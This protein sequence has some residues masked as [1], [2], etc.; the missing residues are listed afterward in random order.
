MSPAMVRVTT[1]SGS[2]LLLLLLPGAAGAGPA[3]QGAVRI[4]LETVVVDRQGTRIAGSD[5]ADIFPDSTGIL[6]KAVTL[7]GRLDPR[8]RETVDLTARIAPSLLPDGGCSLRLETEVRSALSGGRKGSRPSRLETRTVSLDLR[9]DEDRLVEI[10]TSGHTNG[11]LAVKVR[12]GAAAGADPVRPAERP[13]VEFVVSVARGEGD[14]EPLPLKSDA[15]RALLGREASTLFSFN[16]PLAEHEEGGKRYRRETM[17]VALSPVLV[18][19]DRVQV[20]LRIGGELATVSAT[21]AT[22]A[23]PIERRQTLVLAPGEPHGVD[24]EVAAGAD[25]GWTRVRYRLAIGW[26]S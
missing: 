10:Y 3:Q 5:I 4:W 25:E 11:R 26:R 6:K 16:V 1:S 22:V 19:A 24:V 17:E 8:R 9:P 7:Q 21:A 15:L 14:G 13:F 12:C 18:S 2:L 20:E 23:H